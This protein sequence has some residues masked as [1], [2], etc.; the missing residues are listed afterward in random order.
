M[1]K[2]MFCNELCKKRERP[3]GY[4]KSLLP[5]LFLLNLFWEIKKDGQI[6]FGQVWSLAKY[7][8]ARF[9]RIT[10]Q[11]VSGYWCADVIGN[12]TKVKGKIEGGNMICPGQW[13]SWEYNT[14]NTMQLLTARPVSYPEAYTSLTVC[15]DRA[16]LSWGLRALQ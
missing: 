4:S 6:F 13:Q 8:L 7:G 10:K 1:Y 3:Q 2:L 5:L 12:E 11:T 16:Y 15:M 14:L 9:Y